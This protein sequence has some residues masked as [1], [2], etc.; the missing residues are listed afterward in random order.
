MGK[1]GNESV[2]DNNIRL[3]LSVN[4]NVCMEQTVHR[5]K[6]VLNGVLSHNN[7]YL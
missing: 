3:S 7:L 4:N 6:Q 1:K 2:T 5:K